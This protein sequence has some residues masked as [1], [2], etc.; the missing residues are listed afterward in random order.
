MPRQGNPNLRVLE[1]AV[2]LLGGLADDMVF[3]GGCA[4]G[5]LL[6]DAAA[7]PP[8]VTRDVDAIV[9]VASRG[10]YY[11]L[12]A[13]LRGLGFQE[14]PGSD[15][16]MCRW[17]ARGVILDVM[18]THNEILGFGNPWYEIAF[19]TAAPITLP[20]G[21]TIRLVTAPSFLATKLEAFGSRGKGDYVMS[22][23]LEDAVTVVDG[24]RELTEEVRAAD[25]ELKKFLVAALTKLLDDRNF[26]DA[27]PGLLPPD[28]ASQ[29][30]A[31]IVLGRM[32]EV[33][34]V[35]D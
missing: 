18:P 32:R 21:T 29:A 31:S 2:A 13:K 15:A 6:S 28:E 12:A 19:R 16:P 8:R 5:L 1:D 11:R 10:D 26:V 22:H 23:D 7:A 20:S 4:T 14:D 30:R 33:A 17:R 35:S 9:E 24:R 25:D 3:L 27:V 34:G